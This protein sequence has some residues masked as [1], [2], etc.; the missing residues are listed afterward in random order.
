MRKKSIL[1]KNE[2]GPS[3]YLMQKIVQKSVWFAYCSLQRK[4]HAVEIS[5]NQS[6][7]ESNNLRTSLT[8]KESVLVQA[9]RE[10][11]EAK[12][13]LRKRESELSELH[14]ENARLLGRAETLEVR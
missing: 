6:Q 5:L 7:Q 11:E 2:S 1:F 13:Q 14:R 9:Q 4:L 8:H 3:W 12:E 10:R